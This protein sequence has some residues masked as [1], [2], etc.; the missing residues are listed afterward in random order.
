MK[1]IEQIPVDGGVN[2]ARPDAPRHQQRRRTGD[3]DQR[4]VVAR[5]KSGQHR[6]G[7]DQRLDEEGA[8]RMDGSKPG[9]IGRR[10][11]EFTAEYQ[12]DQC[13]IHG[14]PQNC[15]RSD[16]RGKSRKGNSRNAAYQVCSAGF[17]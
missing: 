17:P 16:G 5:Q 6:R 15:D 8:M 14:Q 3:G 10:G 2:L 12:P 13:G 7:D 9:G 4:G 11:V 1:S